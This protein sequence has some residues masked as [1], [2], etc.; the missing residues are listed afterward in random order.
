MIPPA[1][2]EEWPLYKRLESGAKGGIL[3]KLPSITMPCSTCESKQTFCNT[4]MYPV[5]RHL[6]LSVEVTSGLFVCATSNARDV[7][8]V[9]TVFY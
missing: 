7:S 8:G 9:R 2:L 5:E 1:F 3:G 4:E 6:A